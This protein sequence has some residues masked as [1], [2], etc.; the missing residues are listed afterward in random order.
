MMRGAYRMNA[1]ICLYQYF[2]QN[3]KFVG[4]DRWVVF[5]ICKY[6]MWFLIYRD[7]GKNMIEIENKIGRLF[8][9]EFVDQFSYWYFYIIVLYCYEDLVSIMIH[10]RAQLNS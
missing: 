7:R 6:K 5:S 2:Y 4:V 10:G 3:P 1:G 9:I 8:L